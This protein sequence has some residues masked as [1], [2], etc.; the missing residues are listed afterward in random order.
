MSAPGILVV[1]DDEAIASG[2]TRDRGKD[3][4]ARRQE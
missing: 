1:E 3:G 4:P 2:L